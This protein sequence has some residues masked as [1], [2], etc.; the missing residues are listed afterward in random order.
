[1]MCLAHLGWLIFACTIAIPCKMEGEIPM[2]RVNEHLDVVRWALAKNGYFAKT[3]SDFF[4]F[5][6]RLRH[7][8]RF[9]IP[10]FDP[11]FVDSLDQGR[12][13]A[14]YRG[15]GTLA[16]TIALRVFEG[17]FVEMLETG[18]LFYDDPV[19]NGWGRYETGALGQVSIKGKVCSRGGIHSFEPKTRMAWWAICFALAQ[20]VELQC[21]YSAGTAFPETWERS[22]IQRF[23]GYR[24][25]RRLPRHPM[26][27]VDNAL[28]YFV[29]LW[30]S[31]EDAFDELVR[32]STYLETTH[33]ED[34]G[35]AVNAFQAAQ[36]T[37]ER[38]AVGA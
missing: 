37:Q 31:R 38:S 15:D 33:G 36:V 17:D 5:S 32:R 35:T 3:G 22:V 9:L 7:A 14:I 18:T 23:Y 4:E 34:L 6:A 1:L 20:A 16:G 21:D 24:H 2:E 10:Q 25:M 27:F 11:H 13:T 29:L 12:W 30:S 8:G 26:P 19:S 28:K